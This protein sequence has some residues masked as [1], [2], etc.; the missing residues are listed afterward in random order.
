MRRRLCFQVVVFVKELLRVLSEGKSTVWWNQLKH[1]TRIKTERNTA[2]ECK[3]NVL[4]CVCNFMSDVVNLGFKVH[5]LFMDMNLLRKIKLFVPA[6]W[7][8][9]SCKQPCLWHQMCGKYCTHQSGCMNNANV[10]RSRPE[11]SAPLG[12]WQTTS[13]SKQWL[14]L[15]ISKGKT[16]F[17]KGDLGFRRGIRRRKEFQTQIS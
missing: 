9:L 2:E 1:K 10:E 12:A 16:W 17:S 15:G 8:V 13:E 6:K 3:P 5:Y 7:T 4:I 14:L 11:A